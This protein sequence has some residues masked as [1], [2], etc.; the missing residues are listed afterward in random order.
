MYYVYF[1]HSLKNGDLYIGSTNNISARLKRHNDGLVRS[2]KGYIPWELLDFEEFSTRS[3][4][5]KREMFLK[6]HQQ[7]EL[8]KKKYNMAP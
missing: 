1:L 6:S 3:E 8:L 7:K 2:T 4:A 5:F